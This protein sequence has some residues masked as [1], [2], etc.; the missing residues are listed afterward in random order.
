M[1]IKLSEVLRRPGFEPGSP[2]WKAGVLATGP[3]PRSVTLFE[4]RLHDFLYNQKPWGFGYYS[5]RS[6]SK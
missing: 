2:A 3:T 1:M 4:N 6:H 5:A